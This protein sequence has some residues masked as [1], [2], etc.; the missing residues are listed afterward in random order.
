MRCIELIKVKVY[1]VLFRDDL[2]GEN[3]VFCG[4]SQGV[5]IL[6]FGYIFLANVCF[7]ELGE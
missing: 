7:I 1:K 4:M 2:F 5:L 3:V 6:V